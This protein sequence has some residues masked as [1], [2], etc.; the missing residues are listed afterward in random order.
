MMDRMKLNNQTK[1]FF[2]NHGSRF[3]KLYYYTIIGKLI[4]ADFTMWII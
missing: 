1:Y 4:E 2:A 3:K